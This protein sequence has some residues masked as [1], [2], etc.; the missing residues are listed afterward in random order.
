MGHLAGGW[1]PPEAA[2]AIVGLIVLA[3]VVLKR[4]AGDTGHTKYGMA[5][6]KT[7]KPDK[8]AQDPRAWRDFAQVNYSASIYLFESHN[9][10]LIFSAATLG[11]HSLEMY[12]KAAL[13]CEGC[14]VF[15]PNKI[16]HLDPSIKL[17]KADCAWGH[18]LVALAR[19]LAAR[20]PDFDLSEPMG[21]FMPC[22]HSGI[23]TLERGFEIFNPFFSELRYPQ[24]LETMGG[25]G[26]DDKLPL[27]ELVGRIQTFLTKIK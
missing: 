23:A 18:D 11:H 8:Y 2:L 3:L 25:V 16:K 26:E 6:K 5:T 1:T 24:A 19:Q 14:T 10:F 22:Y 20:R 7:I 12:L 13:I 27:K 21:T 4:Y 17:Q 9:P 15:D